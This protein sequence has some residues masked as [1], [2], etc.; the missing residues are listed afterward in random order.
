MNK[1]GINK[2]YYAQGWTLVELMVTVAIVGLLASVAVPTYNEYILT[3]QHGTARANAEQL[4]LFEEAY[5][6]ENGGYLAGT[7][8]PAG[9]DDLTGPL[10]WVPSG[11][12]D[13]YKYVVTTG[14]CASLVSNCYSITVTLISEPAITQTISRP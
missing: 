12:R 9:T 6:Y 10:E 8:D 2:A 14:G 13:L 7:F 1:A 4:A 3:S 5:Y 11:D